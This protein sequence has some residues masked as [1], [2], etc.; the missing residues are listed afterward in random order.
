MKTKTFDCVEMKRAAQE[1]IRQ[2][3]QGMT[4]EEEVEFFRAGAEEFEK[5]LQDARRAQ[6]GQDNTPST[7]R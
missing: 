4:L 7:D 6:A 1:K 2:A 3:V 5:R